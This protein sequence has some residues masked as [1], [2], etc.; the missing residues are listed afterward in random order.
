VPIISFRDDIMPCHAMLHVFA[1]DCLNDPAAHD[2]KHREATLCSPRGEP[3]SK[4]KIRN[5][6]KPPL[7]IASSSKSSNQK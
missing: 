3:E 5:H 1:S 6:Q 2:E 7:T 4:H